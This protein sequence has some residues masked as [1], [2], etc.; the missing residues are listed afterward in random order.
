LKQTQ[1]QRPNLPAV[2]VTWHACKWEDWTVNATAGR[3]NRRGKENTKS[4]EHKLLL[5]KSWL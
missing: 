5:E 3:P 4:I 1:Q 2:T